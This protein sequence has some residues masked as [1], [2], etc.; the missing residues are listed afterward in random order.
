MAGRYTPRSRYGENLGSIQSR[1]KAREGLKEKDDVSKIKEARSRK[2][3]RLLQNYE[4]VRSRM[5]RFGGKVSASSTP[6]NSPSTTKQK[7]EKIA[8]GN[9]TLNGDTDEAARTARRTGPNKEDLQSSSAP[10]QTGSK[11]TSSKIDVEVKVDTASLNGGS[12]SPAIQS[13]SLENESEQDLQKTELSED[14][15]STPIIENSSSSSVENEEKV[16]SDISI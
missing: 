5:N 8:S 15:P 4:G 9:V 11:T 10:Q 2:D 7:S 1:I 14:P 12:S 6:K 16:S 13:K 3:A